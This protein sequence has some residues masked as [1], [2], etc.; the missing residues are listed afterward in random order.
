MGNPRKIPSLVDS[1]FSFERLLIS[2]FYNPFPRINSSI[3]RNACVKMKWG[4]ITWALP[5]QRTSSQI[6]FF[7]KNICNFEPLMWHPCDFAIC[8]YFYPKTYKVVWS[9]RKKQILVI[10]VFLRDVRLFV[11]YCFCIFA[12][13]MSV[14]SSRRAKSKLKH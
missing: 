14:F 1:F 4:P 12:N 8:K 10:I 5:P 9:Q 3:W 6:R 7:T 11:F 2:G 13:N